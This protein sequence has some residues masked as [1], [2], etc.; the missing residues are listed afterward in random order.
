MKLNK[1]YMIGMV[2]QFA[3][4]INNTYA[5]GFKCKI[6]NLSSHDPEV[7]QSP[8]KISWNFAGEKFG[9]VFSQDNQIKQNLQ[10]FYLI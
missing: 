8:I 1:I 6:D 5:V 3:V 4:C 2:A 10:N 7:K 9:V